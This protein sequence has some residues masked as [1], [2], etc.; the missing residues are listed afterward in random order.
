MEMRKI[1]VIRFD[2]VQKTREEA[3][4]WVVTEEK[5]HLVVNGHEVMLIPASP[6]MGKQLAVGYLAGRGITCDPEAVVVDGNTITVKV[7]LKIADYME[8]SPR[9]DALKTSS[10]RIPASLIVQAGSRLQWDSETWKKTNATHSAAL[11]QEDG[12]L[13]QLTEDVSRRSAFDKVIGQGVRDSC[14]FPSIFAVLSCR[15]T[16]DMVIK[17]ANVGIPIMAS[18]STVIEP[19]VTAAHILGVTLLGYAQEDHVVAFAHPE[20][21]L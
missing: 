13:I 14:D 5:Y 21:V 1:P 18:R 7:N 17:A 3:E 2:T 15:I 8:I 11:F 10:P 20:R 6:G 12:T 19:A 9:K 16:E 4:E